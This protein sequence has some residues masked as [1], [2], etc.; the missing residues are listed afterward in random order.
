M[1]S[2]GQQVKPENQ[3]L[4]YDVLVKSNYIEETSERQQEV[5]P[6]QNLSTTRDM[7]TTT[8]DMNITTR[9]MSLATLTN[10]N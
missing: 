6:Q 2:Q 10:T 4:K 3:Q 9:D 7:N 8:R 1:S 5:K